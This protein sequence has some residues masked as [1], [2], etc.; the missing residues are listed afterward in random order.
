M[1]Q[2]RTVSFC[3]QQSSM[4]YLIMAPTVSKSA[5]YVT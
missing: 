5:R 1:Q 2:A 3:E 4:K